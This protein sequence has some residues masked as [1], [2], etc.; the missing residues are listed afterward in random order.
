M[1]CYLIA[2][3]SV[4]TL[5]LVHRKQLVDQ[6]KARIKEFLSIEKKKIGVIGAGRKKLKGTIDLAML[7]TLSRKDDVAKIVRD[8]N[9][10]IIDEC[11]HIPAVSFEAV[12]KVIPARYI[13]GLTATPYRKDGHQAILFMQ[14]GPVRYTM[15]ATQD[16]D[17]EKNVIVRN[18]AFQIDINPEKL[19]IHEIWESLISDGGRLDLL[20]DDIADMLSQSRFPLILSERKDHLY[21][22]KRKIDERIDQS[23]TRGF[24]F[25]SSIGK[26]A[27]VKALDEIRDLLK[28]KQKPYILSTGSLIGEGFDLPELDTLFIAMP[29]SFKGRMIQYAGR[30]HRSFPGKKKVIIYDYC[31]TNTG[32]TI[33]MFKKRLSAYKSMGYNIEYT[34]NER[35]D[36]WIGQG[37]L[38]E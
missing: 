16:T 23:N 36:R 13:V 4:S 20:S 19:A 31:D 6:W 35:I 33:S 7:Q 38:F 22:L 21:N 10:I 34:G 5:I 12:L 3:R 37:R 30:L 29:F 17:I 25:E 8:Y 28:E 11:H 14:C 18:S 2:E 24:L 26:K 27:R 9:Q 1:G 32:L 15:D